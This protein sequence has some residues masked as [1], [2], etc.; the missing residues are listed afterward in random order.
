MAGGMSVF[1]L[2]PVE[3][4][5]WSFTDHAAVLSVMARLTPSRV[6]EFGPGSSTLALIEG[7]ATRIDTCE[8]KP[9]WANVYEARLRA[10]FPDVVRIIRYDWSAPLSITEVDDQRYDLALIDGPRE[11]GRRQAVIAYALERCA[12]VL[13][14]TED[15]NPEDAGL[16]QTVRD[17]AAQVQRSVEIWDTGPLSGG[18]ALVG[19]PC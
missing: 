17:L 3:Q 8:D 7:G 13:V 11:T 19:G 6:L 9:E 2:Y 10:R 14:P 5:W 18:F 16:R 15:A 4:R 12:A 1:A